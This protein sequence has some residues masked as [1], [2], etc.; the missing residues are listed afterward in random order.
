MKTVKYLLG[1]LLFIIISIVFNLNII[2]IVACGYIISVSVYFFVFAT[3]HL[4]ND[5]NRDN[6]E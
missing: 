4:N 6:I 1:M 2:Q 5:T 3:E